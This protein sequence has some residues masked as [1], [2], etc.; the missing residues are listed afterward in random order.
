MNRRL[1]NLQEKGDFIDRLLFKHE[2]LRSYEPDLPFDAF[3]FQFDR[4]RFAGLIDDLGFKQ[5]A[6][7]ATFYFLVQLSFDTQDMGVNGLTCKDH[8][9]HQSHQDKQQYRIRLYFWRK[10]E[11]GSV[12]N[13]VF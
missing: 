1:W 12:G 3:R 6:Q 8:D 4:N 11:P 5:V 7:F 2:A 13:L 9:G 10:C